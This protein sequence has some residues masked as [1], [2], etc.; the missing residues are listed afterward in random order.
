MVT[1]LRSLKNRLLEHVA[2]RTYAYISAMPIEI[3]KA[4][5]EFF[6]S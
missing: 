2:S 5:G 1:D 6:T 3:R 4:Y